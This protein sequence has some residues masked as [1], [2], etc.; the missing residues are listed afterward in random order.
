MRGSELA[1]ERLGERFGGGGIVAHFR[2]R[3]IAFVAGNGLWVST[4]LLIDFRNRPS[5]SNSSVRELFSDRLAVTVAKDRTGLALVC[6]PAHGRTEDTSSIGTA[7][8]NSSISSFSL[9]V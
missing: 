7:W 2:D 4:G 8:S 6:S 3:S 5:Q 9:N 1:T